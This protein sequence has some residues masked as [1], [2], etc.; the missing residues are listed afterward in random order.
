[1]KE[2]GEFLG[3]TN[4]VDM[5]CLGNTFTCFSRDEKSMSR[6]YRFLLSDALIDRWG[7]VNQ[8]NGNMEYLTIVQFG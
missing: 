8:V 7:L 3:N 5:P 2:F 6:I 4:L 1:M